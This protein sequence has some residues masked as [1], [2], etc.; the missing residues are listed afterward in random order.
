MRH[1][2][3]YWVRRV[4]VCPG[5]TEDP[6]SLSVLDVSPT[7][8]D[9]GYQL[10]TLISVSPSCHPLNSVTSCPALHLHLSVG[11]WL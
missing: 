2:G 5:L 11:R 6:D 4:Q 7:P 9:M 3:T 10:T 1:P 8:V